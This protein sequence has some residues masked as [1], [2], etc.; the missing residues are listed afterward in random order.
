VNQ[1]WKLLEHQTICITGTDIG[2]PAGSSDRAYE[3]S[4]LDEMREGNRSRNE[5]SAGLESGTL[6]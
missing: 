5:R 2:F 3:E 6:D 1:E 4:S